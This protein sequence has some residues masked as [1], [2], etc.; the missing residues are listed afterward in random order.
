M[1]LRCNTIASVAAEHFDK[2]FGSDSWQLAQRLQF[3]VAILTLADILDLLRHPKMVC[4]KPVGTMKIWPRKT[5]GD[6]K[7][8]QRATGLNRTPRRSAFP[9]AKQHGRGGATRL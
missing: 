9:C 5:T 4:A 6:P 1:R 7:A 8:T 3:S 2:R